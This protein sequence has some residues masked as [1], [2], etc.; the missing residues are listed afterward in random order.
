[1]NSRMMT[2]S[3][4]GNSMFSLWEKK[5]GRIIST[6]VRPHM[7]TLSK[8]RRSAA[9]TRTKITSARSTRYT[10]SVVLFL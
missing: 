10:V 4:V 7:K 6:S 8:S 5:L 1:M 9:R 3:V 2:S